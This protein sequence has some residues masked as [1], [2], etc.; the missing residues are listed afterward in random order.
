MGLIFQ[1]AYRLPIGDAKLSHARLAHSGN[2]LSGGTVTASSTAMGYFAGGPDNSLTYEKWQPQSLG[3]T[4]EYDHGNV[5]ECDYCAIAAHTMGTS[6]NTLQVQ[7]FDGSAWVD[8]IDATAIADDSAVFVFFGPQQRQRWRIRLTNGVAPVVG[9][10]E[11]GKA[12][13]MPHPIYSGHTPIALARRTVMRSNVSAMGEFIGF[14][15]QRSTLGS[16]FAWQTLDADWVRDNVPSLQKA[17]ESEGC[18]IA[19]R[20]DT[21]GEVTY[22]FTTQTPIPTNTGLVNLMSMEISLTGYSHD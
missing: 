5:A 7:Y 12:L 22:G 18:F 8:L 17:L 6:G 1:P 4:W 9:V 20:P 16:T 10:V 3:A 15:K 21:F 13:Q 2:W 14:T 19:W 11:F